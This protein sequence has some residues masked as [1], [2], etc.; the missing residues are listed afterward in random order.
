[1]SEELHAILIEQVREMRRDIAEIR[2]AQ[3]KQPTREDL[4][5]YVLKEVFE[6]E[7]RTLRE[8]DDKQQKQLD[9]LREK[10]QSQAM[11]WLQNAGIAIG[12]ASGIIAFIKMIFFP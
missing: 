10:A 7:V 5:A 11:R 9:E 12:T 1:M 6:L 2:T 4:Q 8:K 3:A